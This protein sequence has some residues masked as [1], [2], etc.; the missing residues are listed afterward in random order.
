MGRG[1]RAGHRPP[2][3][4]P[5]GP[6]LGRQAEVFPI[7]GAALGVFETAPPAGVRVEPPDGGAHYAQYSFAPACGSSTASCSRS[8]AST[9]SPQITGD[10]SA[11]ALF[12]DGERAARV[13]VPTFDTGAW[14]LYS[15]GSSQHES[16]LVL[17]PAPARLPAQ[18]VHAHRGSRLLRHRAALRAVRARRRRGCARTTTLR[19]GALGQAALR[20]CRRSRAS[21]CASARRARSSRRARAVGL[22]HGTPT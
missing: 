22:G 3:D 9:T 17:P 12:A 10:A 11:R 4:R 19:G 16:D 5:R 21:G 6:A 8:S 18:H 20:G 15:R 1:A 2:G 13:E 7:A 14:S